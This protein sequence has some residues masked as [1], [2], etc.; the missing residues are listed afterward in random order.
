MPSIKLCNNELE[1]RI[2]GPKF[3]DLGGHGLAAGY[4]AGGRNLGGMSVGQT[5]LH[6]CSNIR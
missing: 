1:T 5:K 2:F 6:K 4:C 3:R